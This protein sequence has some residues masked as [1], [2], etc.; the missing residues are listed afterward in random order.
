[1]RD[2]FYA[3]RRFVHDARIANLVSARSTERI[4][5][6]IHLLGK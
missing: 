5:L 2:E 4:L 6:K 3:N 1:M